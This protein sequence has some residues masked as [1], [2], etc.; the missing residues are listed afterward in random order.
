MDRASAFLVAARTAQSLLREPAVADSWAGPSALPGFT[1]GGLAEHLAGQILT[2]ARVLGEP[3]S[4]HELVTVWE[5][6]ARAAWV[7]ADLDAEANVAIRDSGEQAAIE[8][9]QACTATTWRTA[10][11]WPLQSF[12]RRF[13]I[14]CWPCC[15][16][17]LC[18]GTARWP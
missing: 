10:C 7:G 14:L 5:H 8:G 2:T 4:T 6:Y 11:T 17:Y 9:P 13:R 1:I 3:A 18:G 12:P 16:G 15:S